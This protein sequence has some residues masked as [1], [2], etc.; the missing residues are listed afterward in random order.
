MSKSLP[1]STS[2]QVGCTCDG[3]SKQ[4]GNHELLGE[5]EKRMIIFMGGFCLNCEKKNPSN[6]PKYMEYDLIQCH[7]S[8]LSLPDHL[9]VVPRYYCT[10]K[11]ERLFKKGK[12]GNP[13]NKTNT[14]TIESTTF[15]SSTGQVTVSDESPKDPRI[16]NLSCKN[17]MK[18]EGN[19]KFKKCGRCKKTVYCSRQCQIDNWNHH[20]SFCSE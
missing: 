14:K 17:C 16:V 19:I 15:D 20:K 18:I 4:C 2:Q 3:T 11:C 12:Y 1:L 9:H 8:D 6:D 7:C 10:S 13:F 5:S